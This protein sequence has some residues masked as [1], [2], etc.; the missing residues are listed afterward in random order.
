MAVMPPTSSSSIYGGLDNQLVN[1]ILF[2]TVGNHRFLSS[3]DD[4]AGLDA[5]AKNASLDPNACS[6]TPRHDG[7]DDGS[8]P[9]LDL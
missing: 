7:L 8:S 2:N 4:S 6:Y 1:S 9:S 3:C 5:F